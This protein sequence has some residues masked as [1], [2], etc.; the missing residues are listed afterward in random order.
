MTVSRTRPGSKSPDP[1]HFLKIIL[2]CLPKGAEI[3]KDM[4]YMNIIQLQD[5]IIMPL[6]G[7]FNCKRS[8][9]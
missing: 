8:D 7:L 9:F 3:K 1:K 6:K 5:S 2:H 4:V